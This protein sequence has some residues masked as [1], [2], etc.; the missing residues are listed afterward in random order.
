MRIEDF[1]F[2]LP[3]NRIALR[4]KIP[5]DSARLLH[6]DSRGIVCDH[7]MRDFVD[8]IL[9]TDIVIV[10]DTKVIPARLEAIRRRVGGIGSNI[11]ITLIEQVDL[12]C[13]KCFLKPAKRVKIG[14]I[15]DF[16]IISAQVEQQ[17]EGLAVIRFISST[18]DHCV[19]SVLDKIGHMPLPPY[20]S[21]KRKPDRQD[22][23]DYQTIF[24]KRVGAIAAPTAGLHFTSELQA[25]LISKGIN[26]QSVTLHV[27]VGTFLPVKVDHIEDHH[28]HSEWG[29]ISVST[30]EMINK[31][32][33]LGGRVICIG[34]TSLRL[35]ETAMTEDGIL[36]SFRG[37]TDIFI[38]PGY[39][40]K[41][42][43][44]LLTNFHLPRST[45]FMLVSAFSGYQEIR[46]AYQY[47]IASKYRFFSYGDACFLEKKR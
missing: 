19:E 22:M 36:R 42:V 7:V 47:A 8:F 39:I 24:A 14:D 15:L 21:S 5:R 31:T 35:V 27:G 38:T 13:W 6:I 20:I 28:M 12:L 26:I 9:P 30:A 17:D 23:R 41:G 43:N 33:Q 16:R 29:E 34:T 3:E 37:Y 46:E 2:D 4:P 1:D 45:L 25:N 40:F 44:C 32:R 18:E 10:N 11:E